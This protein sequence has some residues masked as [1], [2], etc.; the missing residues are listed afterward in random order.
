MEVRQG[1]LQVVGAKRKSGVTVG[2][3][4]LDADVRE[5]RRK[6][7]VRDKIVTATRGRF[8]AARVLEH[9]WR[10]SR[11]DVGRTICDQ[12]GLFGIDREGQNLCRGSP[13]CA[14]I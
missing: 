7:E 5:P 6:V 13:A 8:I 14:P 12:G 9:S 4:S 3:C 10:T 1:I 11:R 2:S